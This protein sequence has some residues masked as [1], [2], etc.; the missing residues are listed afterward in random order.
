[1]DSL[2][3]CT[4]KHVAFDSIHSQMASCIIFKCLQ[5]M[6]FSLL[7]IYVMLTSHNVSFSF[8]SYALNMGI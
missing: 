4:L 7:V 2:V 3:N 1:M 5:I 6:L 8:T